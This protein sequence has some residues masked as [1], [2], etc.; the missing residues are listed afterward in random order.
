MKQNSKY[1][2]HHIKLNISYIRKIKKLVK[3]K[4]DHY[5]DLK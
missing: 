5:L 1:I 3:K 2:A 4:L